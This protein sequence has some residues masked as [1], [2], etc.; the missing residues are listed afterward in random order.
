MSP[1]RCMLEM[2]DDDKRLLRLIY[3]ADRRW[4]LEHRVE[5]IIPLQL[6]RPHIGGVRWWV[7]VPVR[8]TGKRVLLIERI[9]HI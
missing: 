8:L 9:S 4:D 3:T 2:G 5:H 6:T 7:A 1:A